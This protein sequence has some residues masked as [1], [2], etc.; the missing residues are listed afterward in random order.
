MMGVAAWVS[1]SISSSVLTLLACWRWPRACGY[2]VREV[3]RR[4]IFSQH[5]QHL[6]CGAAIAAAP[7]FNALHVTLLLLLLADNLGISLIGSRGPDGRQGQRGLPHLR[8]GRREASR[9]C[10]QWPDGR[11]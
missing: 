6:P 9:W 7:L 11:I 1:T 4:A 8:P 2:R 5:P 10:C 3:A